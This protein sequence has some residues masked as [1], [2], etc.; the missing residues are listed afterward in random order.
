MQP[1]STERNEAGYE[2]R[3]VDTSA[4]FRPALGLFVLV[5][6]S[7]LAMWWTFRLFVWQAER[8]D[9]PLT[10]IAQSAKGQLPPEPRLQL[11]PPADLKEMRAAEDAVLEG[12]AWV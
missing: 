8:R 4:V 7:F 2:Q 1:N 3:D 11:S 10:P 9:I 12:Y 6:F 5:V